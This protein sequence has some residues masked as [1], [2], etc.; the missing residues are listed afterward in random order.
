MTTNA[1]KNADTTSPDKERS[2]LSSI[3]GSFNIHRDRD[4]DENADE[5]KGFHQPLVK[6]PHGVYV[7]G[8]VTAGGGQPVGLDSWEPEAV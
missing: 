3:I 2:F 1:G 8:N 6:I 4:V 7:R 5:A